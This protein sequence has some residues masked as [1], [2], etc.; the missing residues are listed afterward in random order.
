MFKFN[1]HQ[2]VFREADGVLTGGATPPEPPTAEKIIEKY[3]S[4]PTVIAMKLAEVLE[5]NHK[6]RN[7]FTT[8]NSELETLKAD[9]LTLETSVA[10][11]AELGE[12]D[13]LKEA[14]ATAQDSADKLASLER[15]K[16]L[17]DVATANN[18]KPSL[19]KLLAK[20]VEFKTETVE[21]DGETVTTTKVL[22]GDEEKPLKE[23]F[24]SQ[25]DGVWD[26][27]QAGE[28]QRDNANT[29]IKYPTQTPPSKPPVLDPIAD[30]LKAN[31]EEAAKPN[32]LIPAMATV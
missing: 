21:A 30:R 17:A 18:L 27:L 29:G 3:K 32:P 22:L 2:I 15:D 16:T 9:K 20:D 1:K 24:T 28:V 14:L 13:T 12:P 5:D 31:Q 23:Y 11:Y 8:L 25:G 26:S 6:Y 7:K 19:L 10:A 4:D